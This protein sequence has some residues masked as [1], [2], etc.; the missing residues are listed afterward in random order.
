MLENVVGVIVGDKVIID[1]DD[2][3]DADEVD[4]DGDVDDNEVVGHDDNG[5]DDDI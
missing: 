5:D 2:G 1:F 4:N 3:D